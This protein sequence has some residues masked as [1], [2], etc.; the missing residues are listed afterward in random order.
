MNKLDYIIKTQK[1]ILPIQSKKNVIYK[2]THNDCDASYIGQTC[3]Q[4]KTVFPNILNH[5]RR[6]TSTHS[7][8][9]EHRLKYSHEFDWKNVGILDRER[10]LSKRLILEMLYIKH[11]KN[12]L[13]LQ[14]DTEYL[15]GTFVLNKL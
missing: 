7:V 10:Y 9:T 4:L 8:I 1:D 13:N 5:I 2:L 3:R 6:Y 11:Q 12:S 15:D 14:S